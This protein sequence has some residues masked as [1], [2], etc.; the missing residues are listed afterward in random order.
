VIVRRQ[1]P[2]LFGLA[3]VV[4]AILRASPVLAQQAVP[5]FELGVQ[6][7]WFGPS[8]LGDRSASL[9]PNPPRS[10]DPFFLFTTRGEQDAALGGGGFL[11]LRLADRFS[12][13]GAFLVA[14]P[15]L[16][17]TIP[18]DVE[19]L[20]DIVVEGRLTEY[21]VEASVIAD[22]A[23]RDRWRVFAMAGA[24]YL[25]QLHEG[26]GFVD[27]GGVYHAG[28][29]LKY[30]VRSDPGSFVKGLGLR[31]HARVV[32]RDEGFSLEGQSRAAVNVA[33][34]IFAEF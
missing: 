22:I 29:G 25:R 28:G 10:V 15:R 26:R 12:L 8:S 16:E 19:L 30:R 4:A 32:V 34:G 27:E 9:T 13:E 21:V 6:V 2:R 14:R 5:R 20:P 11:A 17:I 24:G 33:A 18:N 3:F 23:A 1:A 7:E 31:G